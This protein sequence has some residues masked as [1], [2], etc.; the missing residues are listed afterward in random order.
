M[1]DEATR[2]AAGHVIAILLDRGLTIATAES[3]TGGLIIGAL[4]EIPGSSKA[5]YGGFVTYANEAKVTMIGV[6]EALIE[7]V[8][9]VSGQVAKA[10]AEGARHTAMVD[11]AIAVTGIAGPDGGSAKKPV[12]LVHIACATA[13]G[14]SH[15]ERRFGALGRQGIR[16]ASVEAALQLALA[17]LNL[18]AA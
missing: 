17:C 2:Q 16:A 14:T 9:A 4:T 12:G 1:F 13:A 15:V 5:V 10:M 11:I 6:D 8:G 7:E 18:E 3:C